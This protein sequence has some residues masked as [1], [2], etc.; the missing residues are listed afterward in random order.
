MLNS[1][2]MQCWLIHIYYTVANKNGGDFDYILKYIKLFLKLNC[3][4]IVGM[5][6]M[7]IHS[8]MGIPNWRFRKDTVCGKYLKSQLEHM[9]WNWLLHSYRKG[10]SARAICVLMKLLLDWPPVSSSW[11]TSWRT[12]SPEWMCLRGGWNY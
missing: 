6:Y 8:K 12:A 9:L 11:R 5:I 3:Y 2:N 10:K 4:K 1:C 7:F